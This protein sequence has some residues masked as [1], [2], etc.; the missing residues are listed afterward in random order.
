MGGFDFAAV[1]ED[2]AGGVDEGLGEVEGGVVDFGE[3]EGDV[4]VRD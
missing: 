2:C 1:V 4:A 3:A